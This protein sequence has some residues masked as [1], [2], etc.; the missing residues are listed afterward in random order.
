MAFMVLLQRLTPAERAVLLLHDVFDYDH[1]Q[2]GALLEKSESNCR[3]L[4]ERA[5]GHVAAERRLLDTPAET[6]ARLLEAFMRAAF[7]GDVVGLTTLLAPDAVLVTDGGPSGRRTSGVRN[8]TEP[9]HGADRIAAFVAFI[10]SRTV[11]MLSAVVRR[12]NGQPAMVLYV[13]HAPFAAMLL[14]VDDERVHRVFFHADTARLG[15]VGALD[16]SGDQPRT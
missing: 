8:L 14:G 4:L 15:H 9:L 6:H 16:A 11:G 5:R 12:L 2:V 3:K 1:A 10:T 7:T 13:D